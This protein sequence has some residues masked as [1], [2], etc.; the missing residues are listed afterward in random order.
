MADSQPVQYPVVVSYRQP[1]KRGDVVDAFA[2]ADAAHD[3]RRDLVDMPDV[4]PDDYAVTHAVSDGPRLIDV[5]TGEP[6][7]DETGYSSAEWRRLE[8]ELLG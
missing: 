1:G 8:A 6:Y 4:D 5:D 7:N 2:D 3:R